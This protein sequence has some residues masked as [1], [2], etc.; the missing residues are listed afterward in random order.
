MTKE[1]KVEIA[2]LRYILHEAINSFKDSN[3][4]N[5][6][7]RNRQNFVEDVVDK[8]ETNDHVEYNLKAADDAVKKVCELFHLQEHKD[9]EEKARNILLDFKLG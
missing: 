6:S 4:H 2:T 9:W 7:S 1:I 8:L 5:L 3:G